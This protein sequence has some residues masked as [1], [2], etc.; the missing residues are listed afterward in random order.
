MAD[1]ADIADR[2]QELSLAHSLATRITNK[3]EVIPSGI[4]HNCEEVLP[5]EA[6][7]RVIDG[8]KKTQMEHV[9]PFCDADC[10]DDYLKRTTRRA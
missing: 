7:E 4:C 6:V 3:R 10:R 2:F 1:E 9:K 8:E 5:M